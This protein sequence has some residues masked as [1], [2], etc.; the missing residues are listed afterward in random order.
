MLDDNENFSYISKNIK[1]VMEKVEKAAQKSGRRVEDITVIAVSKTVEVERIRVALEEGFVDL[2]ENK[3]Q[4]LMEK[5]DAL[6]EN[7][8]WHLI[9]HLQTNKV[10]Y[11]IDKVRMIHS[12]DSIELAEEI[13]KRALKV[14]RTI[15]ILIQVNVSGE[16]SKFGISPGEV[17]A[18]IRKL[19]TFDHIK[20]K[21]LMTI[22]PYAENQE[23]IRGVF[24]QLKKIFIDINA[25]NIDN[26]NME[27]LSMGMSNDF[28]VAIEEGAN[29]VRIG[30]LIFG[31]RYYL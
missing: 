6:G 31:K 5:Y 25:E 13:Q 9:G 18:F 4:E 20:V 8:Q 28:E 7:C 19:S 22:A 24:K 26:I 23:D 21:G 27:F 1:T 10:K 3:V 30:T 16:E 14:N 15:D 12:V 2:G 17:E 11:I 29:I